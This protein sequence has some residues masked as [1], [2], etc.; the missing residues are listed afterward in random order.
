VAQAF[1]RAGHEVFVLTARLP[2]EADAVRHQEPGLTVRAIRSIPNPRFWYLSLKEW[3]RGRPAK[4]G[5]SGSTQ[6]SVPAPLSVPGWKRFLGAALWLPDDKQGFIFSASAAALRH[7][8]FNLI[9]STAP[10]FS[11]HLA[12]LL[13]KSVSRA[14][15]AA[16]FRDPWTDNP[17]KPPHVRTT[18][19]ERAE[20]W[21]ERRV[22]RSADHV[23][24][25]SEG[26]YRAM[27]SKV[28]ARKRDPCLLV[29]NGIE[30]LRES[31]PDRQPGPFRI[32]H[33]G[34]FYHGRDPRAFLEALAT[35]VRERSLGSDQL[36]LELVG[37]CR[38]FSGVSV[39]REVERLGLT[40]MVRFADWVPHEEAQA[41]I[42]RADLLLLLAQDQPLQVPNK[43]YEYLGTRIPILAYADEEGE[44]AAIL[45][46]AGA[47]YLV[48]P[49][50]PGAGADFLAQA[51]MRTEDSC[52]VGNQPALEEMTVVRQMQKLIAA[53]LP[54]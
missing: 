33:I 12:A 2:G 46:E 44:S 10:P 47:H 20:R 34:S 26:I 41:A 32:V 31:P 19:T 25:V 24:A 40:R 35:V 50:N 4:R 15:W 49:A 53:V 5:A 42:A 52:R 38:W 48:T 45:R 22:L 51:L 17:W 1:Q 18:A 23:V 21:L 3:V 29:R 6:V 7:G 16:E 9:Y 8:P 37:N 27:V 43:L 13:L 54:D 28:T 14:A 11:V 30:R 39:E 36:Q